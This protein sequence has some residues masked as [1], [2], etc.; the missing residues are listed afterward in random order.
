MKH[1]KKGERRSVKEARVHSVS[2]SHF[3]LTYLYEY[4]I[5]I[6]KCGTEADVIVRLD[7]M[8]LFLQCCTNCL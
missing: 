2:S 7:I 6:N 5:C 8:Y 4:F 1:F 3:Q